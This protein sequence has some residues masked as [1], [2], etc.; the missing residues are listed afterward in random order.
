VGPPDKLSDFTY[1]SNLVDA[2]LLAD[3]KLAAGEGV[4]GEAYFVTN[5]EP[6][7]FFDFVGR[8]LDRLNLPPIRGRVPFAVA[9]LVA[10]VAEG[11]DTLRGGTLN[12]ENGLSRFAVRYMCL[13]HY[14]SI[15]KARRELGYDPKVNLDEGIDLTVAALQASASA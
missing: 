10:A 3:T 11:I 14:F 6:T 13:H 15:D 12:S 4:A 5:G 2:L 1:V 7:P 9:Y 8:V